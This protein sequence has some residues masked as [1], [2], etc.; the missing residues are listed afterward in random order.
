MTR[1]QFIQLYRTDKTLIDELKQQ[2]WKLHADVNQ[3]Y[4]DQL[5]YGF[6]LS[7]TASYV[8][9]YGHLTAH[10][11]ADMLTLYGGAYFH[12]TIEDARL[13]YHDLQKLLEGISALHPESSLNVS[14]IAD[15]VYALTNN[16]G[17]TR[18]ERADDAYYHLI[19]QTHLAP[20]V[21]WCDRLAN[22]RYSF[23]FG[24]R[25]R[26]CDVYETEMPHFIASITQN[27]QNSVPQPMIDEMNRL[28]GQAKDYITLEDPSAFENND[29][30]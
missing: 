16:R 6:H 8:T 18:S 4:G 17:R 3:W 28:I 11:E 9:R 7:L 30:K 12:D 20:F 10:N 23:M 15:V 27:E 2:A 25:T 13:T 22:Y 24:V 19:S 1:E 29:F 5:P 26:M 14:S 21:K